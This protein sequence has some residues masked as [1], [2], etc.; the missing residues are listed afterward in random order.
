[1]EKLSVTIIT[2]DE[3]ANIADALRSVA[4][5]DETVVVDSGSSDGTVE[6]AR[7][8]AGKVLHH[9]WPGHVAQKNYAVGQATHDWILSIDADERVSGEL[10]NQIKAI[11]AGPDADGY[12]V[13]RKAFYLGRWIRH[14]GWYPDYRV[15]L[16]HRRRASWKGVDP[17]DLVAVDGKVGTIDADI[18]HYTYN[19][20]SDHLCTINSYTTIS[21]RRYRELGRRCRWWDL[22][23]R[24][25]AAFLQKY[26]VKRGFLDGRTGLV[27][28]LLHGYYVLLKYAKLW[29]LSHGKDA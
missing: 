24:P 25:P 14:G 28:C 22:V 20:I 5:A 13:R 1:M 6:I 23:L 11:L 2:Q 7:K 21:A 16:F 26:L 29:E 10:A 19:S 12:R 9:D 17:H 27:I 18:L 4:F 15:R 8:L 3:E